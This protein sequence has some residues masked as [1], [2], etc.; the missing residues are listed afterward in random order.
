MLAFIL[1]DHAAAW[2]GLGEAWSSH[3]SW[4]LVDAA[5]E[6][7]GRDVRALLESGAPIGDLRDAHL[8]TFVLSLVAL[9][10]TERLGLAPM[11]VAGYGLGEYTALATAGAFD[12]EAGVRLV[13]GRAALAAECVG[14]AHSTILVRGLDDDDVEAAC[15]RADGDAWVAGYVAP[16]ELVVTGTTEG[17]HSAAAVAATLGNAEVTELP[18][19]GGFHTPLLAAAREPL[20]KHLAEVAF[21]EPDPVVVANVDA[22]HHPEASEWPG[23]LAAQLCAPVR[24]RQSVEA[25][26]DDGVRTFVEIGVD[27]QLADRIRRTFSG[28]PVRAYSIATPD[29]LEA[30]Q[31]QLISRTSGR[32]TPSSHAHLVGRF[33][34]ATSAGPFE[35]AP[36]IA[37]A[38]PRLAGPAGDDAKSPDV[39]IRVG[40]LIGWVGGV[41]V[42]S[43]FDGTLGG[44]LVIKG[45]RVLPSQPVAWLQAELPSTTTI[46]G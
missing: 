1:P 22:R 3:E 17:V 46:A 5:S 32:R 20:R 44:L 33:V 38:A 23:L 24:W 45:E 42:R 41:E 8:A 15:A 2:P 28:R 11:A 4:E 39:T 18:A 31:E 12:V 7:A 13:L 34:V 9:D 16:R 37:H 10:A 6:A 43:A 26:Y 27:R 14:V 30:L 40:D 29:E 19:S 36:E 35:P 25:L 21:S